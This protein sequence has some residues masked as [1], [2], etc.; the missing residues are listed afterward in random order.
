MGLIVNRV[1][2]MIDTGWLAYQLSKGQNPGKGWSLRFRTFNAA[3]TIV[4]N[5]RF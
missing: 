5:R 4:I 3:P 1:V 2:S